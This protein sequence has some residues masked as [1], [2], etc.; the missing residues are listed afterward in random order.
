MNAMSPMSAMRVEELT[1]AE[2]DPRS[3]A[4]V[5]VHNAAARAA[6]GPEAQQI[7]VGEILDLV[8]RRA[9]V[10]RT[11]A[12]LLDT[13]P[14]ALV[15]VAQTIRHTRENTD[16]GGIWLSVAPAHQRRGHGSRLLEHCEHV[17]REEGCTRVHEHSD[18]VVESGDAA[19]GFAVARGYRQTLLHL[20]QDLALPV[21]SEALDAAAPRLDPAA[22]VVETAV[23]R[24]PEG[25]LEDRAVLA[26]RMSTDAPTGEIDLEEAVWDAERVRQQWNTAS[27]IWAVETVARHVPSGRLVGFTDLV[28]RPGTPHLAVQTDTL[29]LREHRGHALGLAM[30]VANLRALQGEKPE[31]MSIRT[32]NADTNTHM[33][34]INRGLG[35]RVTGWSREWTKEL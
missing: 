16:T 1:L 6:G 18:S 34:A 29:V 10:R 25:W 35:F 27:P 24:L 21:A 11:F 15:A 8:P 30:K 22:Y 5:T 12:L 31:V 32:W 2:G 20:G 28:V 3:E 23:D 7:T 14:G 33:L 9:E 4:W 26:S 19:S 13:E 17:L